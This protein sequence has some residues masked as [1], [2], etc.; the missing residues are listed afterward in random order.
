MAKLLMVTNRCA[1]ISKKPS[2]LIC[3]EAGY[4]AFWL[5]RFLNAH[6]IQCLVIDSASMQVNRRSR[7]A[8][9][10]RIDL[11]RGSQAGDSPLALSRGRPGSAGSDPHTLMPKMR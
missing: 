2:I 9:T 3:Y 4:D 6:G 7:R 10:D 8:K 1:K 11:G 5:A